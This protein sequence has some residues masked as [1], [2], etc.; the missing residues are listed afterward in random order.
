M[1]AGNMRLCCKAGWMLKQWTFYRYQLH[2]GWTN[3]A[4][5]LFV[6]FYFCNFI[7]LRF[8]AWRAMNSSPA[9]SPA[10]GRNAK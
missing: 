10:V 4:G 6:N 8:R 3:T 5:L 7:G 9:A 1:P 2:P